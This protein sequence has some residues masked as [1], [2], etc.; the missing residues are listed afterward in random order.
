MEAGTMKTNALTKLLLL[1]AFGCAT[2][3]AA[4]A[5]TYHVDADNPAAG[6]G[7]AANPFNTIEAGLNK[8]TQGDTVLVHKV[9]GMV[10]GS[11]VGPLQW[12]HY[13]LTNSITIEVGETLELEAGVVVKFKYYIDTDKNISLIVAGALQAMGEA[14]GGERSVYFTS[15][16]DNTV[17]APSYTGSAPASGDWHHIV[18]ADTSDD[19]NCIIRHAE[20]R[21][22]G[23]FWWKDP[24]QPWA[25]R[26][27][28]A[29]SMSSASPTIVETAVRNTY[30][31]A[32]ECDLT[33]SPTLRKLTFE[34]NSI[35]AL[36]VLGGT[37]SDAR[38][39]SN[40]DVAYYLDSTVTVAHGTG[41]LTLPAGLVVKFAYLPDSSANLSLIVDG[42]L[43]VLGTTG[44]PVILTSA[45]D[46]SAKVPDGTDGD[47][48]GDGPSVGG[49]GDWYHLVFS[50][51]SD[52][53]CCLIEHAEIRYAG[54]FWWKDPYQPWAS[55]S[56]EAVLMNA[57]SPTIT[58]TKIKHTYGD[59]LECN[60]TSSPTLERLTFENNTINGLN[61]LGG[62]V[63]DARTW[64]NT[65]VVYYLDSSV[66][67]A[68]GTGS[69]TLAPG[70]VVKFHYYTSSSENISFIVNGTLRSTGTAEE[71]VIITS[72]RDDTAKVPDGTDG[73]TNNDGPSNGARGDWHHIAF[74]DQSDDDR[75]LIAYTSIKYAGAYWWKDPYQPWGSRPEEGVLISSASPTIQSTRF[76]E[77]W[78]YPVE[79]DLNS[80]PKLSKLG[81]SGF[82]SPDISAVH[83]VGGTM[84]AGGAW[85]NAHIPYYLDSSVTVTGGETLVIDPGTVIKFKVADNIGLYFDRSKLDAREIGEEPIVLT[86]IRDDDICGDTNNDGPS[87]GEPG[88]WGQIRLAN[89]GRPALGI[90][91][92]IFRYAGNGSGNKS[93]PALE[94]SFADMEILDCTF[95]NCLGD[96]IKL[97][98]ASS[99]DIREI[100]SA[101]NGAGIR[102]AGGSEAIIVAW[103]SFQDQSAFVVDN[104]YA[105]LYNSI[106][107][108][109]SFA[110][111]GG[112][113]VEVAN[114]GT[115]GQMCDCDVW[116]PWGTKYTTPPGDLTGTC[117]NIS[118]NPKFVDIFTDNLHLADDS[119]CLDEG[120]DPNAVYKS[121]MTV[122]SGTK[123]TLEVGTK[124][125]YFVA[126]DWIAYDGYA[127]M[128]RVIAVDYKNGVV[129]FVPQLASPS[130]SGK[131]VNVYGPGDMDLHPRISGSG[132]DMGADEYWE[133]FIDSNCLPITYPTYDDW[134]A[135]GKP[136]CWCGM[137]GAPA[138]PYQCDGDAANRNSG[139]PFRFR[140]FTDDLVLL[141]DNWKKKI[142]DP[143]L[144]P[145]ADIDH[146]DSGVPFKFRVFTGDLSKIVTNWK[147]KD[148]DL[149]GDCPRHQAQ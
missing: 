29:V 52:D 97:D 124:A 92:A 128:L 149:P 115:I 103:T 58:D 138:W 143:T 55:R 30:G 139:V 37:I 126:M 12:G 87:D 31:F 82:G 127:P 140:V 5:T 88:D 93:I 120:G 44:R 68:E 22:A 51:S 79:M 4:G 119:P 7:S 64:S 13:L 34:N 131:T 109:Y 46:D 102:L 2:V 80:F 106:L 145:C 23:R 137:Y 63:E 61:M 116:S 132:V 94:L 76:V 27:E 42:C 142:S 117:G 122:A 146:K 33:S 111:P 11:E 77:C 71:P 57:A 54:R 47:A 108:Y 40:T 24:Y 53:A 65:D 50:D 72:I 17:G 49:A 60:L 20:I 28:E 16:R 121:C 134:L 74:T 129:T 1:V 41:Q 81:A 21:Y 96:G 105:E 84:A 59:A 100:V 62:T 78:G 110:A 95:E 89:T 39:W 75:C 104:A 8:A 10:N 43:N 107:S 135:L 26:S 144:D 148:T 3:T 45:R 136:E 66:T 67:I 85:S 70:M 91:D 6:D 9:D 130:Q 56:E 118:R 86:S 38:T 32:L 90:R 83:V 35:N 14:G 48:N 15:E 69:L 19:G 18:F 101:H 141:V 114:G 113:G 99:A 36:H 25:S 147:Q 98:T 125:S 73:D 133:E 123:N 112:Y